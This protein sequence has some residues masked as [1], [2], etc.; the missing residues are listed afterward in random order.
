MMMALIALTNDWRLKRIGM[1]L[2]LTKP[3][4][5]LIMRR[6]VMKKKQLQFLNCPPHPPGSYTQ[7]AHLIALHITQFG[8]EPHIRGQSISGKCTV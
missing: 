7:I 5:N 2:H 3:T 6:T 8:T 4:M 1:E